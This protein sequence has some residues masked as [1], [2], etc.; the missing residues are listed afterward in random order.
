[1][2]PLI[3]F[4]VCVVVIVTPVIYDIKRVLYTLLFAAS[5]IPVYCLFV[6]SKNSMP[7]FVHNFNYQ[8]ALTFQKLF[9]ALPNEKC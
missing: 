3:Y 6:M 4:M 1:M 8:V 9:V 2:E 5:G 7:K